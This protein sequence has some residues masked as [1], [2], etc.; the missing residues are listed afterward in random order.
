MKGKKWCLFIFFYFFFILLV[1]EEKT[2]TQTKWVFSFSLHRIHECG[3]SFGEFFLFD[4]VFFFVLLCFCLKWVKYKRNDIWFVGCLNVFINLR[5]LLNG[6]QM[7]K[8]FF[9][10]STENIRLFPL[11]F[12]FFLFHF[13][14]WNQVKAFSSIPIH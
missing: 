8:K 11:Q 12:V 13:G 10:L 5:R 6:Q 3:C 1:T 7:G 4:S 2:H 9:R 14:N